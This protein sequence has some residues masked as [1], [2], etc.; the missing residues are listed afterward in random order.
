IIHLDVAGSS[1]V[2]VDTAEAANELFDRRSSIY[3]SRYGTF[4]GKHIFR[5]LLTAITIPRFIMLNEL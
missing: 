4:E 5:G 3:S 1:I 2:V